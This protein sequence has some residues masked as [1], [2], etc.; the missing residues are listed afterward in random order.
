MTIIVT[1]SVTQSYSPTHQILQILELFRKMVNDCI[2]IGLQ[3]DIST[4][5][6]LSKLCYHELN[7][8]DDIP[9]YYKLC[10]ISR[11]A[12]ILAARKKSIKRGYSTKSPYAAKPQL[13]SCYG[14]KIVDGILRIPLGDRRYF[15]IHLNTYS[16]Q[17]LASDPS[18]TIRSFTMTSNTV[19]ITISKEV[20]EIDC[21]NTVGIDRNLYNLTVGDAN[22]I[23]QYDLS[24]AV[25]ITENTKLIIRSFKRNDHRIRRKLSS[26]YGR[27]RKNRINQ[28]LH[29]VSKTVV[30]NVKDS[31]TAIVFEDIRHIRRLYQRGNGQGKQFRGL[32]NSWSFAEIKRLITYKAAWEKVPIFQLSLKE[33]RGTSSLC[34]RCG[35]RLQVGQLKRSLWCS[36]CKRELDRDVVAAMNISYKGRAFLSS[37]GKSVFERPEGAASEAM[38]Q[39][40]GSKEPIIL[41]VDAAKL[42][43]RFKAIG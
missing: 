2:E 36:K 32:L 21:I 6:A 8:Y 25:T 27:R 13:I 26:K 23:I 11:A 15:D 38:V 17:I 14:F 10:A 22:K 41:K 37:N 9:S 40:L 5:K 3:H 35:E 30:R 20:N 18:L 33:T 4:M 42:T 28:L 24:K 19:N 43:G 31:K 34:P 16:R 29:R 1:K 39:E 7:R 12:G